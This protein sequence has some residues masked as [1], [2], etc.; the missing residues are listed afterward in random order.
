MLD[1]SAIERVHVVSFLAKGEVTQD[2]SQQRF[3]CATQ[4]CNVGTMLQPFT[5]C[6]NNVATICCAKNRC[7]ESSRVTSP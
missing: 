5:Q 4:H 1:F 6:R 3:F 2:D 7:C